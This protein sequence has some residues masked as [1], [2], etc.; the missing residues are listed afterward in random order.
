MSAR[1][2]RIDRKRRTMLRTSSDWVTGLQQQIAVA[3]E[4][5]RIAWIK[6]HRLTVG[7]TRRGDI[8]A[9]VRQSAKFC[10]KNRM[11]WVDPQRI[12]VNLPGGRIVTFRHQ[13]AG[14]KQ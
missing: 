11:P 7:L 2:V 4:S 1:H 6:P 10:Q 12:E 13:T 5:D 3:H 14:P 8:T 9:S